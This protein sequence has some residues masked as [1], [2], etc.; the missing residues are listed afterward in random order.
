MDQTNVLHGVVFRRM[1][2]AAGAV[3]ALYPA[4]LVATYQSQ[5]LPFFQPWLV[6]TGAAWAAIY[7]GFWGS[8]I[9]VGFVLVAG[10]P[11]IR[12]HVI[13]VAAL[14]IYS[15]VM[16]GLHPLDAV[17]KNFIVAMIL[18]GCLVIFTRAA[19]N[20]IVARF[21]ATMTALMAV[22]CLLDAFFAD[23]F[24][25][26]AG[27]AAGFSVNANDAAA[28]LVLGAVA[29]CRSLPSRLRPPF[30]ILVGAAVAVTLSRS[31]M[32]VG[33]MATG[34]FVVAGLV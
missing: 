4:V 30:L 21:S 1:P 19:G 18:S 3:A 20:G 8:A 23:G 12:R 6:S 29:T 33:V 10:Y 31:T 15:L 32:L 25:N 16:C 24:T 22:I 28:S 13:P 9:L 27:R 34:L 7:Y 5:F 14:G 26:T 11:H 2:S 17:A